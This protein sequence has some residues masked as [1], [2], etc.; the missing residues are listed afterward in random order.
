MAQQSSAAPIRKVTVGLLTGAVTTIIV[1]VLS[2]AK[3]EVPA[4]V[5]SAITAVLT[6]VVSYIVPPAD[7]D[8]VT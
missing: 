8:Q 3:V 4:I 6:F 1:W 7:T 5:A 2:L